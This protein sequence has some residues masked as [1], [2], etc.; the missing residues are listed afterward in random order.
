MFTGIV[1]EVGRVIEPLAGGLVIAA[2]TVL[3]G[4]RLGDS[5][6]VNGVCLT[7]VEKNQETFCFEVGPETLRLTNLGDLR[8]EMRVNLER[9][10][11]A[12]DR[13]GGHL[14]QGLRGTAKISTAWQPLGQ[15]AW[16]YLIRTFNFKL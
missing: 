14:V 7:V 10:V 11:K 2:S 12:G 16:R 1:E 13:L 15:R 6:C 5:I 4:A 8:P 9:S 3:E